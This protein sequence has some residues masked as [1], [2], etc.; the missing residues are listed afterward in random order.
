[1]KRKALL[2]LLAVTAVTTAYAVTGFVKV[3]NTTY[4]VEKN[5]NLYKT[6]CAVCHVGK[7]NKLNPYGLDLKAA[8]AG[9]KKLTAE[10]LKAVEGKDSDKDGATNLAEIKAD[11]LPGDPNSKPGG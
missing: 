8:M 1:M 3:F 6:K 7:T 9:S 2:A 11:M 5:S 10:T 4:G